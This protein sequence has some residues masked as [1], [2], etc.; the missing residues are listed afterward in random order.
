MNKNLILNDI[1]TKEKSNSQ[2]PI[3]IFSEAVRFS[4]PQPKKLSIIIIK[5]KNIES[6][7]EV[8]LCL[9]QN[10]AIKLNERT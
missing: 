9:N 7:L 5:K 8:S 6:D 2:Q 3:K 10:R 4:T 1:I